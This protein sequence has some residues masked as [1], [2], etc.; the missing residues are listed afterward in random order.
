MDLKWLKEEVLEIMNPKNVIGK[1]WIDLSESILGAIDQVEQPEE[2]SQ[3]WINFFSTDLENIK[4]LAKK[5]DR[6][7]PASELFN[8]VAE[9]PELPEVPEFVAERIAEYKEDETYDIRTM[10]SISHRRINHLQAEDA[11]FW[12]DN[13]QE[14]FVLAYSLGYIVEEKKYEVRNSEGTPLIMKDS[15]DVIVSIGNARHID[16]EVGAV[17]RYENTQFTEQEIR[18]YDKRYWPFAVPVEKE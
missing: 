18:D 5:E 14:E 6:F 17:Q 9:Q 2:L 11:D 4:E 15:N 16:I 3:E 1:T 8:V 10:L 7:V 12:I 13:N